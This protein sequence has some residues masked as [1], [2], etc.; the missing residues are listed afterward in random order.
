M[1]RIGSARGKAGANVPTIIVYLREGRTESQKRE[2]VRAITDACQRILGSPP[3]NVNI[4][5]Q[6]VPETNLGKAG[7]LRSESRVP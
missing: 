5:I 4:V 2:L 3:D 1:R 7:R 6:D